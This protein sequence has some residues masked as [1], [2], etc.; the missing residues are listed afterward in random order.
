MRT[1]SPWF[2]AIVIFGVACTIVGYVGEW[3]YG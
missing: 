1:E 2:I 3:V